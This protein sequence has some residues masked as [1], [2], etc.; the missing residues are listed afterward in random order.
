MADPFLR[1]I[2]YIDAHPYWSKLVFCRDPA[3]AA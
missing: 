2:F 1:V 3:E